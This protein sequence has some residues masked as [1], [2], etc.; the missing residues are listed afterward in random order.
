M[1]IADLLNKIIEIV[2][3]Q[4]KLLKEHK[5]EEYG[6]LAN[7]FDTLR[8]Q[9]D[10]IRNEGTDYTEED[11]KKLQMIRGIHDENIKL[12]NEEF[13]KLKIEIGNMNKRNRANKVYT[14]IYDVSNEAGV[15]IDTK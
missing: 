5:V 13:N 3:E 15:F 14:G 6:L 12:F 4:N 9:I 7:D 2:Q 10:N 11:K 1:S 8:T